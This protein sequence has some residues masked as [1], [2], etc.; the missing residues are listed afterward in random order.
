[1]KHSEKNLSREEKTSPTMK[2]STAAVVLSVV[3]VVM[4]AVTVITMLIFRKYLTDTELVRGFVA[5]HK[6]ASILLFF[7]LSAFQVVVAVVPGELLE[8]ACGYAFGTLWGTVI[9][10]AGILFGSTVTILLIRKFGTPLFHALCPGKDI[11]SVPLLRDKRQRNI[12]TALIFFIPGTPKDLI[13]Y[14]I[15]L[16]DMSIPVYLLL[17]A[18]C[19]LPSIVISTLGG[20]SF[21]SNDY[22]AGFWFLV[23]SAVVSAAGLILYNILSAR[24]KKKGQAASDDATSTDDAS[25]KSDAVPTDNTLPKED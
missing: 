24:R 15:G 14:V 25:P 23:A 12:M 7:L 21:G 4:C 16:T 8:I 22:A 3:S 13:T 6:A 17:T 10:W 11:N 1:M 18:F 20:D 9:C 5:Q 19:R 2:K